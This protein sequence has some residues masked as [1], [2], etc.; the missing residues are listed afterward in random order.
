MLKFYRLIRKDDKQLGFYDPGVGTISDSSPWARFKSKAYGVFGLAT[1][2]GLDDNVLEAYR[3]LI[4]NYQEDD[5]IYLLGFS[6]GGVYGACTG[7]IPQHGRAAPP[8]Q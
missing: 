5:Q 8:P 3:F 6:R 2:Y 4:R 7:R 1:G